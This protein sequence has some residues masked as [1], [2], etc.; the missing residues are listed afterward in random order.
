MSKPLCSLLLLASV[1]SLPLAAH[2]DAIDDFVLTGGGQTITYSLP[3]TSSYPDFDLF[4]FF[5]ETAPT[6]VNGVSVGVVQSLYYVT[7]FNPFAPTL[8]LD[9]ADAAGNPGLNLYGPQFFSIDYVPATNPYPYWQDDVVPTFIP[10]TYSLQDVSFPNP[11]GPTQPAIPYTLTITQETPTAA[12]PEPP[13]LA[14]L[15]TGAL[16]LLGLAALKR[17][18]PSLSY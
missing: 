14:L 16:A 2:A 15:A 18:R 13:S 4:N 8:I 17:R 6:T 9:V 12:T 3:A 11:L 10:G 5:R 7:A 1:L